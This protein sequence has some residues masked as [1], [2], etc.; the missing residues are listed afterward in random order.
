MTATAARPARNG[1]DVPTLFATI[2]AVRENP[3]LADTQFRARN[4]W[5]SGTHNRSEIQGFYGA[6]QEDTSRTVPF[7][8]DADHPEVF[9]GTGLGPAPVE[10][11]LHAIAACLTAG[12]ANIAAARGIDLRRV[13]STVERSEEHTSELQSRGHLVCRLLLE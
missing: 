8:Y 7:V 4:T 12:L 10:F 9:V 13:T 6:G 5:I 2:D 1:V 3:G 11:L